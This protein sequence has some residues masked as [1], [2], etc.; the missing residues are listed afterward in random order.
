M[1][2]I[3]FWTGIWPHWCS[4]PIGTYQ[5][6]HW[7][8]THRIESQIIDFCQWHSAD[9]LVSLT[10]LFIGNK[11]KFIGVSTS[12]WSDERVPFNIQRAITVIKN[13]YPHIQFVFGGARADSDAIKPLGFTLVGEAENSLLNLIKGHNISLLFDITK[14]EHRFSDNDCIIRGEVLPIELGRGC[15]FKCKFCGHHNLGK[16]KHTYQ[17]PIQFIENEISYNYEKFKTTH[18]HFL[19]DTVNEDPVKVKNLS[20]IPNNTGVDIK[21]N[22]YLRLDLLARYPDTVEQLAT[23]GMKSCFFGVET[24]H[25]EASRKIGKGWNGKHAKDFL[26]RLHKEFWNGDI[27]IWANFIV[28]LPNESASNIE[29]S[30]N[31][32]INNPIGHYQ[33]VPLSLYIHR[34]DSGSV[35]DFNKNYKNYGYSIDQNNNWFNQHMSQQE[36]GDICIDY[37]K[38]LIPY[39][40]LSSWSLFD[41]VSCGIDLEQG[42]QLPSVSNTVLEFL[43]NIYIPYKKKLRSL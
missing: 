3:I 39:N 14:L 24:F 28:G 22:G 12:F 35:S 32:C 27:N 20:A 30:F 29:E 9:E 16:L 15:I 26:P 41:A 33:F 36:A 42:R 17:R 4:R 37:N 23:S 7:L 5:L 25:P 31:W 21:W 18:Y 2:E 13:E 38:K 10:K 6:A 11:T 19:D 1:N 34:S 43:T 40:K 8:R